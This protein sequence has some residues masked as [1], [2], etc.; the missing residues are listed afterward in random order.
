MRKFNP[1]INGEKERKKII[2]QL[3]PL[4]LLFIEVSSIGTNVPAKQRKDKN[5][6]NKTKPR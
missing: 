6:T 5:K 2:K 3:L 4:L 1:Y